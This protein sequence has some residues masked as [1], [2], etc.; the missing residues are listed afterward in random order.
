LVEPL[1]RSRKIS[2]GGGNRPWA[3]PVYYGC[4]R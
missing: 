3:V 4:D 2:S 1:G